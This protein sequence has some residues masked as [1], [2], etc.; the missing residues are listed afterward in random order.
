MSCGCNK[1]KVV[2]VNNPPSDC[3]TPPTNIPSRGGTIVNA[4]SNAGNIGSPPPVVTPPPPEC[5]NTGPVVKISPDN[6]SYVQFPTLVLMYAGQ[7]NPVIHYT[8]DNTDPTVDSPVYTGPILIPNANYTIKARAFP[9]NSCPA[10]P[11]STATYNDLIE[12]SEFDFEYLCGT[13][14]NVG[15]FPVPPLWAANGQA[16]DSQWLLL[17]TLAGATEIVRAEIYQ[18]DAFGNWDT[19][20]V[21]ATDEYIHPYLDQSIPFHCY[22][23]VIKSEPGAVQLFND[24][25]STLGNYIA[26]SY[27]WR[28]WGQPEVAVNGYFTL[29]LFLGDGK[30]IQRIVV[31]VCV[32]PPPPC[33][34]PD[35]P[36]LTE[37]CTPPE[38]LIEGTTP[39]INQIYNIYRRSLDCEIGAWIGV[40]TGVSDGSGDYSFT[41]TGVINCCN[42]EYYVETLC[43]PATGYK[44][45]EIA[46][47]VT[48]PCEGEVDIDVDRPT[49]C[50]GEDA[51]LTWSSEH[52]DSVSIDN[53]VGVVAENGS[54][55]VNPAVTTTYTITCNNAACGNVT[56]QVTITVIT[57]F[58][59]D[60]AEFNSDPISVPDQVTV[61]W[62]DNSGPGGTRRSY[63]VVCFNTGFK[64]PVG[65]PDA[66]KY[67]VG[68]VNY[69]SA[70][71]GVTGGPNFCEFPDE[72]LPAEATW[73]FNNAIFNPTRIVWKAYLGQSATPVG[74][75]TVV[76]E[77]S[78]FPGLTVYSVTVS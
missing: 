6:G 56:A 30:I 1:K 31:A 70:S 5:P 72:D 7:T 15:S 20:Q 75:Y 8:L 36:T 49:I 63:S 40:H 44:A 19:G 9:T 65:H 37:S 53:G 27:E 17:F 76:P 25:Q 41:D 77:S 64:F 24:Y 42:Y 73:G 3:V 13:G 11:I 78:D 74:E 62:E 29:K 18:T 22:P 52:C 67:S 54:V 35:P 71:G 12:P 14:D 66:G 50:S 34:K 28:L 51:I 23:L 26:G 60:C 10:G 39:D 47:P 48:V 46:G 4:N 45:S 21:W 33:E 57:G 43:S 69:A 38:I 55:E 68:T 32:P 16:N 2:Q 58:G 61:T 59:C